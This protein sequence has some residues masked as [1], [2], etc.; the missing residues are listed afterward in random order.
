MLGRGAV[1]PDEHS[2]AIVVYCHDTGTLE[3]VSAVAEGRPFG[4]YRVELRVEEAE[5]TVATV[6][7]AR[8]SD[9]GSPLGVVAANEAHALMAIEHGADEA[10]STVGLDDRSI[11]AFFERVLLRARLR[12]EQERLQGDFV[13]QE[14]L[15]ALGTLVAGVAHEINNPLTALLLL[16][17]RLRLASGSQDTPDLTSEVISSAEAIASV[18]RDL[19]TFARQEEDEAAGVVDI[20]VLL[21]QVVRMVGARVRAHAAIELDSSPE[22]ALVRAPSSRLTQVFMNLLLNAA[23]AVAE[24]PSATHRIRISVRA[25]EQAV[26]VSFSDTGPGVPAPLLDKVFDPFFTTK[27]AGAGTGLGLS[28]SRAILRRLGGDLLLDSVHGA[29]ATFVALIPAAE[30][31]AAELGDR[32][33]GSQRAR[34][35]GVRR[36]VLVV[37]AD[38]RLLRALARGLELD[39]DLLLARDPSEAM[40]LL[41]SGSQVDVI[42]ADASLPERAGVELRDALQVRG[43]PLVDSL[44]F[45]MNPDEAR[46]ALGPGDPGRTLA[47]PVTRAALLDAVAH[48]LK[49]HQD[50]A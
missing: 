34:P 47:K 41:D 18:V 23:Q 39:Y 16:A 32:V 31:G 2:P 15:A 5:G 36:R 7:G 1:D 48:V 44:V 26:A 14:K 20:H 6:L 37:E 4:G 25:D 33:R 35:Q 11:V 28:V 30:V 13:H 49:A 43:S 50:L 38:E 29:G 19:T 27:R 9:G 12:K 10:V 24:V 8:A 21:G 46:E 45:M 40:T 17:E 42:V 22:P 3:R